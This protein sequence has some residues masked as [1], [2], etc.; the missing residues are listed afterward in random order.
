MAKDSPGNLLERVQRRAGL[1]KE[2]R[3]LVSLHGLRHTAASVGLAHGVPLIAVSQQLG[4]ARVDITAKVYAHLLD[5]SQLDAF[6]SAHERRMLGN[7]LGERRRSSRR[8]SVKRKT[9]DESA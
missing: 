8:R 2:E 1:V 7:V 4:H 5:D 3:P 9:G 6:A